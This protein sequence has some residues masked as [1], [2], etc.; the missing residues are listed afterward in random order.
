MFS[1]ALSAAVLRLCKTHRLSYE[2]AALRCGISP[3]HYASVARKSAAPSILVLEKICTGFQLTPNDLLV[4]PTIRQELCFRLPMPVTH[5]RRLQYRSGFTS[6]PIC[7][8]CKATFER[9]YQRY[10]DRCGQRLHWQ[11]FSKAN[12]ILADGK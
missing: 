12:V 11:E 6:Y 8:R 5:V 9:E 7:P 2:S 1:D 4:Q 10:C 3:S